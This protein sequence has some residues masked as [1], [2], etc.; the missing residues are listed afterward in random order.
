M[1]SWL[2][3]L[4]GKVWFR[5]LDAA[6]IVETITVLRCGSLVRISTKSYIRALSRR[7]DD[8]KQELYRFSGLQRHPV[9]PKWGLSP[10]M[11]LAWLHYL[12]AKRAA[13]EQRM[14]RGRIALGSGW[15]VA[16]TR[17]GRRLTVV[18]TNGAGQLGT[19]LYDS[20]AS[21]RLTGHPRRTIKAVACG[22]DYLACLTAEDGIVL[23]A[24]A[25]GRGQLGHGRIGGVSPELAPLASR[26]VDER[27]IAIACGNEFLLM[28]GTTG[29]VWICGA[30]EVACLDRR[31]PLRTVSDTGHPM[32]VPLDPTRKIE[33]IAAGAFHAVLLDNHGQIFTWG[34]NIFGQLG[35]G[36]RERRVVPELV[37]MPNHALC[38]DVAAGGN[39]TAAIT[40]FSHVFLWGG[41]LGG[42]RGD[43]GEHSLDQPRKISLSHAVD[44]VVCRPFITL[45]LGGGK[46][47]ALG[48]YELLATGKEKL[49]EI[50]AHNPTAST[51][52]PNTARV[53]ATLVAS[54]VTEVLTSESAGKKPI[55]SELEEPKSQE[56]EVS[57]ILNMSGKQ[58]PE[59]E[60]A[61]NTLKKE[62]LV[63]TMME[64]NVD[65]DVE[66][67]SEGSVVLRPQ[68]PPGAE[69][70]VEVEACHGGFVVVLWNNDI[71]TILGNGLAAAP[72]LR[73][74]NLRDGS[75]FKTEG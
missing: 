51:T 60:P 66:K 40:S 2:D 34:L 37:T 61:T 17:R 58:E 48:G 49:R 69:H 31:V 53:A 54:T 42:C 57:N 38:V 12:E 10:E 47:S 19:G 25:N 45:C 11:D 26:T 52:P 36:D 71:A 50:C 72:S 70:I 68:A 29:S 41:H 46:L 30:K 9:F 73:L 24:G 59:L 5:V 67:G 65:L 18:G 1:A 55:A 27:I 56:A 33:A 32:L 21:P 6:G 39:H 28:C 4:P 8:K 44:R 75:S 35:L 20:L 15:A 13:Q 14:R 16:V 74:W 64:M 63:K 3:S 7:Y 22:P 43:E 62:D 23:T